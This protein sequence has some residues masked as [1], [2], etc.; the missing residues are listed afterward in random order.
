MGL[1]EQLPYTNFHD[2]NLTELIKFVNETIKHIHE[3]DLTIAEQTQAINDFKDYVINY[4]DNLDVEGDVINYINQLISDGVITDEI[5]KAVNT[6]GDWSSRNIIYVGD[7][8]GRGRTYPN[9]YGYSWCDQIDFNLKPNSSYN[10]S[11]SNA[12]FSEYNAEALR[13]GKQLENFVNTYS[14]ATCE[15]ITDIIICGGYNEVFN[16]TSDLVDTTANY[17]A[18]WT[19]DYIKIHFPNARVFIGFI[20]RVPV[21]GGAQATFNNF[22]DAIEKYKSIARNYNW[23]YLINS[24]Y[25]CHIYEELTDDGIHFKTNGYLE[26]GRRLANCLNDG[27]WIPPQKAGEALQVVPN[28]TTTDNKVIVN[29]TAFEFFI[30]YTESGLDFF[31]TSDN[32]FRAFLTSPTAITTSQEINLGKYYD[33]ASEVY[34]RFVSQYNWRIPCKVGFYDAGYNLLN[35]SD[36][37]LYLKQDGTISLAKTAMESAYSGTVSMIYIHVP[38]FHMG[39]SNS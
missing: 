8:Y 33:V 28:T 4:L 30:Q 16:P 5:K 35:A 38:P 7:S 6:I 1:F 14:T 26:I 39:Y 22:R 31:T 15:G 27:S 13:Y 9:T 10:M 25:M 19:H 29:A 12:S 37:M 11:V 2:L 21:F 20:G 23:K 32:A 17:C 34:S 36:M 18:K 3:M 24:E